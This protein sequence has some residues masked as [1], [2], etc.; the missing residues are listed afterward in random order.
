VVYANE[1]AYLM[2]WYGYFVMF[3]S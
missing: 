2:F 1:P 3:T